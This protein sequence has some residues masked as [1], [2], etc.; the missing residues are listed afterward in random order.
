M[1]INVDWLSI[2]SYV[3]T[4]KPEPIAISIENDTANDITISG[5]SLVDSAGVYT[6]GAFIPCFKVAEDRYTVGTPELNQ[7]PAWGTAEQSSENIS[8]DPLIYFPA[9]LSGVAY[10]PAVEGINYASGSYG[11][12]AIDILAP[13]DPLIST[14]ALIPAGETCYYATQ[15]L[16]NQ[17]G[18]LQNALPGS[19]EIY[20]SIK[21]LV[22]VEGDTEPLS[23][24]L[25]D[26]YLYTGTC[27]GL[28]V[29]PVGLKGSSNVLVGS[30]ADIINLVQFGRNP[31]YADFDFPLRVILDIDDGRQ[32]DVTR[33]S[34]FT[35]SDTILSVV[36]GESVYGVEDT[37]VVGS[38]PRIT[39]GGGAC[40]I[41]YDEPV[42]DF[43]PEYST[44]EAS[45][46]SQGLTAST[47]VGVLGTGGLPVQFR[48]TQTTPI[49]ARYA[50]G[51]ANLE[52]YPV[53]IYENGKVED[54]T[55]GGYVLMEFD[56]ATNQGDGLTGGILQWDDQD[57]G[58]FYVNAPQSVDTNTF[59]KVTWVDTA[60][61]LLMGLPPIYVPVLVKAN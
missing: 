24:T 49:V 60:Y 25:T 14:S 26:P 11:G 18:P 41:N 42:P 54:E 57:D 28:S 56:S 59:I 13:S 21:V 40:S 61:P 2:V 4:G 12:Q 3:E 27:V 45:C 43:E 30:G 20:G 52:C 53:V 7:I 46:P 48:V 1:A 22:L 51:Q 19:I 35:S 17:V 39:A 8:G 6:A 16:S 32:I 44:L 9:N 47:R 34:T 38:A 33:F 15:I 5:I 23:T 10:V 58:Y 55:G 31:Q 50:A 36:E 37:S 29:V